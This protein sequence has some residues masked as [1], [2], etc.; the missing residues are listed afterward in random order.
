MTYLCIFR[1]WYLMDL[2]DLSEIW[3]PTIYFTNTLN[4]KNLGSF[5]TPDTKSLWYRHPHMIWYSEIVVVTIMCDMDFQTF[6]NDYHICEMQMRNWLGTVADVEFT[7]PILYGPDN[8]SFLS[9]SYKIHSAKLVFDIELASKS[10]IV[11]KQYH[12]DYS[13]AMIEIKI[14]RNSIG[15]SKILSGYYVT[16]ATFA[17]ISLLSFFVDPNVV[18]S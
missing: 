5:G 18:R 3:S 4:L 9:D 15:F 12:W 6:P 2:D 8:S 1:E 17:V 16:T 11:Y 10:P 13:M 14:F 7:K